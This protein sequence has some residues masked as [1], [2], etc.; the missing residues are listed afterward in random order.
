MFKIINSI[1]HFFLQLIVVLSDIPYHTT[2]DMPYH[3]LPYILCKTIDM[4][5]EKHFDFCVLFA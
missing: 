2:P 3:L 4:Q 5:F 1:C